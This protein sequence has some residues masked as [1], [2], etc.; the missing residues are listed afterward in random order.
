MQNTPVAS[1]SL[2][3]RVI[4]ATVTDFPPVVTNGASA[5]RLGSNASAQLPLK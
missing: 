5:V 1:Y 2:T 3:V 4:I